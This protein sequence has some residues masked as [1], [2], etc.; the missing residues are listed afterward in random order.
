MPQ[1]L[2]M[3]NMRLAQT[4]LN[5][6]GVRSLFVKQQEFAAGPIGLVARLAVRLLVN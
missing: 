6:W 1:E 2:F 3:N 5:Y 4:E